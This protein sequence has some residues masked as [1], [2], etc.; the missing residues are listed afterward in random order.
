MPKIFQTSSLIA[1][2]TYFMQNFMLISDLASIMTSEAAF[3][4][5]RAISKSRLVEVLMK[6]CY[7]LGHFKKKKV[8]IC[9]K[10]Q[11]ILCFASRCLCKY[12]N[13]LHLV[14]QIVIIITKMK[15]EK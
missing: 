13:V 2:E 15:I 4:S 8:A 7:F 9:K 12:I 5:T 10:I 11:L 6:R 14:C 1:A 3:Q